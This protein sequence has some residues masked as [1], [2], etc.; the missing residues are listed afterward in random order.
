MSHAGQLLRKLGA[1]NVKG[2]HFRSDR[3][4]QSAPTWRKNQG[5]FGAMDRG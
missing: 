5:F 2:K 1:L 4:D 3:A